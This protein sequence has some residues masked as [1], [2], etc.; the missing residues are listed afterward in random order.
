ML[1][2]LNI[3]DLSNTGIESLPNSVSNLENLTTLRLGGCV[4]LKR[5]PSLA[6]LTKLRKLDLERTEIME[7]PH[8]LE[9][10]VNLRYLNLNVY[11]LKIMPPEILP[12]L[13]H[14]QYLAVVS[15][16]KGEEVASLKNLKTFGGLCHNPIFT[17]GIFSGVGTQNGT[18]RAEP[19]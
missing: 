3:L 18:A 6:K 7:V 5:V 16:V 15:E 10:L 14:L 13:S 19:A 11:T 12:K 2:D 1:S 17:H 8:G 4:I 9:M